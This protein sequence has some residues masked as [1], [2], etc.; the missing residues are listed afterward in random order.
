MP[1]LA[2]R[3]FDSKLVTSNERHENMRKQEHKYIVVPNVD[4]QKSST[5][6]N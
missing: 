4:Y 1:L 2:N 6:M 3:S 5:N